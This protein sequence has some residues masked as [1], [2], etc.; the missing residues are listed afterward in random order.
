MRIA[1]AE[2]AQETDSF[3]PLVADLSDFEAYGLYFGDEILQRMRGVGPLGGF[4]EVA[5]QRPEPVVVLPIMRAWGSAGGT[6]A[7]ETLDYLTERL[8]T[9][10]KQALPVDAV[11]LSLHGAA[12]ARL[13]R[14]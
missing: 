2:F 1:L 13:L 4:L 10:L 7:T 9:D 6:I 5:G 14:G 11:F 3:S 12:A 8:L